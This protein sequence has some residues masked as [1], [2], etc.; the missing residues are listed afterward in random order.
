MPLLLRASAATPGFLAACAVVAVVVAAGPAAAATVCDFAGPEVDPAKFDYKVSFGSDLTLHWRNVPDAK[1]PSKNSHICFGLVGS[2]SIK[3]W[4][5]FGVSE[6]EQGNMVPS[7]IVA[8]AHDSDGSYDISVRKTQ[9]FS[10]ADVVKTT[11]FQVFDAVSSHAGGVFNLQFGRLVDGN[12]FAPIKSSGTT[13]IVWAHHDPA[14]CQNSG[15]LCYH[16]AR[17]RIDV[18]FKS[19]EVAEAKPSPTKG[20]IITHGAVMAGAWLLIVPLM[21]VLGHFKWRDWWFPVHKYAQTGAWLLTM[22]AFALIVYIVASGGGKHFK[23]PHEIVGLCV[24]I[25]TFLQPALGIWADKAYD[26]KRHSTPWIPDRLH[27]FSGWLL[28][29]GSQT[30]VVLGLLQ[31]LS[32]YYGTNGPAQQQ[33]FFIAVVVAMGVMDAVIIGLLVLGFFRKRDEADAQPAGDE[34][35]G[36]KQPLLTNVTNRA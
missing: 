7:G 18:N 28:F 32:Y 21:N 2:A 4:M 5:G 9:G 31:F 10:P 36:D 20:W 16:T 12:E 22:A 33:P 17:D 24:V 25:V 35:Y 14:P 19:G 3:G 8:L 1:D 26:P 27:I 23:T 29:A 11:E 6:Q 15:E 34:T 13:K 30:A